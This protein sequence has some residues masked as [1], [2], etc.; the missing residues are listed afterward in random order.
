MTGTEKKEEMAKTVTS[1]TFNDDML[2]D[3]ELIS[4][5]NAY[6][7]LEKNQ[8]IPLTSLIRNLLLRT[9]RGEIVEDNKGQQEA[10]RIAV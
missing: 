7:R 8:G 2:V 4:L 10:S 9:L 1:L 3:H 5:A 6:G